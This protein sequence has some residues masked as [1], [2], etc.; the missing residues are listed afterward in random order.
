V[1]S[2]DLRPLPFSFPNP[3]GKRQG[4]SFGKFAMDHLTYVFDG[5]VLEKVVEGPVIVMTKR[6]P[7]NSL[8]VAKVDNHSIPVF[9]LDDY[10]NPVR[11]PVQSAAF[12]MSRQVMGTIDILN[13]SKFHIP[14]SHSIH[15]IRTQ[16]RILD[17]APLKPSA[18][19]MILD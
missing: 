1:A 9:A 4:Q 10:L 12:L 11:V 2:S 3:D 13:D 18:G 17:F 7:K 19:W 15:T 5:G 16:N 14:S 6:F 8:Q